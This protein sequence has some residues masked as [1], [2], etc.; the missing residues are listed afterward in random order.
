MSREFKIET[1]SEKLSNASTPPALNGEAPE[2]KDQSSFLG[3]IKNFIGQGAEPTLR[4]TI[5]EFINEPEQK[6]GDPGERH[7]RLLLANILKL[8]HMAVSSVM[9]PR[10]NIVALEISA[11]QDELLALLAEKQFSRIPVYRGTLDDVLGTIHL[12]D[13]LAA[14]AKGETL[15]IRSL[16]KETPVVSPAMPVIDLLLTMRERRRHMALVVDE[17]GGIDGLVTVND[18]LETIVGELEDEHDVEENQKIISKS[19]GS[20]LVD[21]RLTIKDFEDAYGEIFTNEE[22]A[23]ADTLS[24]LVFATAGRIPAR[25]EIITHHSGMIFEIMDADPRRIHLLKI[26]NIPKP[27]PPE[28]ET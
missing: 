23:N 24:G 26:R 18:V 25:G 13:V 17:Y 11:T 10:A 14:V 6:A 15:N 20:I 12:K 27:Q 2:G 5:D 3:W 21:A 28:E 19:D 7:E 9:I 4:E 16:I 1:E 8:R 22:R